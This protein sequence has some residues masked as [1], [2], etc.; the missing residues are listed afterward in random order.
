M[1]ILRSDR[2]SG[3]GG[4]NAIVGSTRF[5]GSGGGGSSKTVTFF[6]DS[7]IAP[8]TSDFCAEAWVYFNFVDNTNNTQLFA[9]LNGNFGVSNTNC[10]ALIRIGASN[11]FFGCPVSLCIS[12]F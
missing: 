11:Q 9:N 6:K 4:A 3:L 1:G 12:N 5:A 2:V 10:W 7:S 8:G